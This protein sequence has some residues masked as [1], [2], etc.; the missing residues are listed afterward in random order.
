MCR[1]LVVKNWGGRKKTFSPHQPS[2]LLQDSPGS[3]WPCF[4]WWF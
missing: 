3:L 2:L 4:S 1:G